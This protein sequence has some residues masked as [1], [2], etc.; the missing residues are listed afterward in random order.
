[1]RLGVSESPPLRSPAWSHPVFTHLWG[2]V[3]HPCTTAAPLSI[4]DVWLHPSKLTPA[5]S[6]PSAEV[7]PWRLVTTSPTAYG[8][9]LLPRP[10]QGRATTLCFSSHP[11]HHTGSGP[12]PGSPHAEA[13]LSPDWVMSRRQVSIC[14]S[15]PRFMLHISMYSCRC[16]FISF[17]AVASSS[18]TRKT[19]QR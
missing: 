17:L 16:R 18:C 8:N 13:H 7:V 2:L 5:H 11:P 19:A 15:K 12:C 1:M 9:S 6:P 10:Q 4:G 14:T 3:Q